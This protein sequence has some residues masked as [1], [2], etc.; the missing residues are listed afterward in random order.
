MAEKKGYKDISKYKKLKSGD[1]VYISKM[2]KAIA[3]FEIGLEPVEK[4]MNI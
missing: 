2:N 3:L 4:G 1:K